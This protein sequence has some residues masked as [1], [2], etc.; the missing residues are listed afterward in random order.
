[1]YVCQSLYI[2]CVISPMY[3]ISRT[4]RNLFYSPYGRV[5]QIRVCQYCIY[6]DKHFVLAFP[7]AALYHFLPT[8]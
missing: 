5:N 4:I 8:I 3:L 2:Y 6:E 7:Y 1:M